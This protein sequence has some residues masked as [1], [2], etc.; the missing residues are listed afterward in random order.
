MAS[1]GKRPRPVVRQFEKRSSRPRISRAASRTIKSIVRNLLSYRLRATVDRGIHFL[2]SHWFCVNHCRERDFY[3]AEIGDRIL[4]LEE[5][6]SAMESKTAGIIDRILAQRSIG[7]LSDDD[8]VQIA[9][10]VAIQMR[11]VPNQRQHL[12]A[13]NAGIR[14]ALGDRD[15]DPELI[16]VWPT[17][18]QR[19]P[20]RC[21]S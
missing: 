17:S 12:M 20:R 6:L 16:E 1:C 8:R 7:C 21:R 2:A 13:M 14:K 11:R 9:V 4:S 15:I 19:K 10:F 3:E 5:G 18:R